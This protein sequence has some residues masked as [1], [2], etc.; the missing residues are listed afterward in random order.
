MEL[1]GQLLMLEGKRPLRRCRHWWEDNIGMD[2]RDIVG[3][4][5]SG[6]G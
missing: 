3:M 4:D 5:I 6:A 2:L 1:V